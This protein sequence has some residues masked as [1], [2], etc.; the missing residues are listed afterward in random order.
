[1][2]KIY[3]YPDIEANIANLRRTVEILTKSRPYRNYENVRSLNKVAAYINGKFSEYGLST[4]R[5][6]F[7]VNGESYA[8]IIGT[9]GKDKTAR[10]IIGA[11]YDVCG[12]QPG[13]DDNASAVAGLLELARLISSYAPNSKYRFD[14]VAY[15]L[16]EPPFFGTENMGSYIHAESMHDENAH[17]RAMICLEMI[18]YFTTEENSQEYP[19]VN[20]EFS[21]PSV[22][23]FIAVVGNYSSGHLVDEV[24]AHLKTASID[25]ESLKASSMVTGVDFSDHR[26]YWKFGYDAVMIT[27]TA[28]Y[29]NPN[30]HKG[31][32]TI[33][34]LDFDK[35]G[36]VVKGVFRALI[37]LE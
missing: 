36:E 35:M 5:Q 28:L 31:S 11:H 22:G 21:Y 18:G 33:E 9:Y 34:T 20:L 8:N 13:A 27:D 7:W 2:D 1:M 15:T 12:D 17:I 16:E 25:V 24:E 26:N 6:S 29:R 37:N 30:Y 14:F 10:I 19:L 3:D 32:D 4:E 23:N